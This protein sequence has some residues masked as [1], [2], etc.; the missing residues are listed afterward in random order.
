M[1][2]GDSFSRVFVTRPHGKVDT[3]KPRDP[4]ARMQAPTKFHIRK[5]KKKRFGQGRAALTGCSGPA[6]LNL[7]KK[8][9]RPGSARRLPPIAAGPKLPPNRGFRD[10]LQIG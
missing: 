4:K 8:T 5:K 3:P 7:K 2:S 9:G 1:I 6:G 10:F